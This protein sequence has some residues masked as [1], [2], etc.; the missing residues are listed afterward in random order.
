MDSYPDDHLTNNW[1]FCHVYSVPYHFNDFIFM[2]SR[3]Q[4]GMFIHDLRPFENELFPDLLR[5]D[6]T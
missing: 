2:T 1:A 4:G 6:L 5:L 3:F